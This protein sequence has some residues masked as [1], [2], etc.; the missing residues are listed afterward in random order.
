MG[1]WTRRS[2]LAAGGLIGGGLAIGFVFAP[3]R[4]TIM[5]ANQGDGTQLNTWVTITPD[6][7]VEV[8][9]PHSEMGQGSL[10]GL[11]MMLA[12]ELDADW[13]QVSVRQAPATDA[14]DNNDVARGFVLG[15]A[16]LPES[17]SRMLDYSN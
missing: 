6:N 13:S 15:D 1:K 8:I 16:T 14:Y 7:K 17:L 10:T 3:N 4:M 2:F 12:E 5:G 9:V 11:P